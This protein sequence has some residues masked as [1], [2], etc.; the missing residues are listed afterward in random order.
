MALRQL[1]RWVTGELPVK[2]EIPQF[3]MP[4]SGFFTLPTELR[5]DIYEMVLLPYGSTRQYAVNRITE[6]PILFTN[7]RIRNEARSIFYKNVTFIVPIGDFDPVREIGY[8]QWYHRI[9]YAYGAAYPR[10]ETVCPITPNWGN[11]LASLQ[12]VHAGHLLPKLE[13]PSE[14]DSKHRMDCLII[15]HMLELAAQL[16]EAKVSWEIVGPLLEEQ[17]CMLVKVDKRWGS[18]TGE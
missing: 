10:V 3:E 18:A 5:L 1:Q 6:P 9:Y 14:Q 7:K 17:Q 16:G 8:I 12:L 13:K 11:L 2:Y 4:Q 15:C